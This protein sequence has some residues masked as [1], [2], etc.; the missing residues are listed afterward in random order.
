[1][2]SARRSGVAAAT[3]WPRAAQRAAE[4]DQAA[5]EL[6]AGGRALELRDRLA[7]LLDARVAA[8]EDSP[9]TVSA[10]PM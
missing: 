10:C 7:Q 8:G 2:S 5:G 9:E 4:L 6:A 1:M 3:R